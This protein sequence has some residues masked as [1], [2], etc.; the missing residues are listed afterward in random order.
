MSNLDKKLRPTDDQ[1]KALEKLW[2]F[3][4]DDKLS[5]FILKGYAGTGK[6]TLIKVF[7]TSLKE[8]GRKYV[9]MASTGRAAKILSDKTN[10]CTSTIHSHLYSFSGFNQNLD[11]MAG[12]NWKTSD[13]PFLLKFGPK[14][15]T[16][17]DKGTIF[18]ID[19]SS[20]IR[21]KPTVG[22]KQA[23][24][25]SGNLLKDI[26]ERN[27]FYKVIFIGDEC[28]LPPVNSR[29][30]PA[31]NKEYIEQSYNLA[32]ECF[33]LKDI[34][35]QK[36]G[37]DIIS[38]S[39]KIRKLYANPPKNKWAKFPLK[40]CSNVK[41]LPSVTNLISKYVKKIKD[42]GYDAATLITYSNKACGELAGIIRTSLGF[43]PDKLLEEGELLLV[44]QNNLI[45]GLM[46]GDLVKV[47]HVG[48]K[49]SRAGLT[50]IHV[51][52]ESITNQTRHSQ[53]IIQEIM[54]SVGQINL[55]QEQQAALYIDFARRMHEM[56]YKTDSKEFYKMMCEDIYINALRAVYGYV[57]TCHKAQGGEWKDVY[58]DIPRYL[59]HQPDSST[60]QWLYTSITRAVENIYVVDD[61]YITY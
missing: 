59:S 20:M 50:F 48:H 47:T 6:T 26:F 34:V 22:S 45:S 18:I 49:E 61:F 52:V 31:L 36:E 39:A 42:K 35:R 12:S 43:S 19:E 40:G 57:L 29:F 1:K 32:T 10:E 30:S 37:N 3:V 44:T 51:E 14:L 41:I 4:D 2:A 28:Q 17:D 38:V 46:N 54:D 55:T 25:G 56:G 5:V 60:Y 33:S 53:L 24:F 15:F 8:Y 21:D 58:I 16:E 13:E 27:N 11:K 7:I 23:V 9:L